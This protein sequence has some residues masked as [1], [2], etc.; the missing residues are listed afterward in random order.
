MRLVRPGPLALK[1]QI[2]LSDLSEVATTAT[3]LNRTLESTPR[4][5]YWIGPSFAAGKFRA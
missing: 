3:L 5:Q 2:E 4:N 1:L